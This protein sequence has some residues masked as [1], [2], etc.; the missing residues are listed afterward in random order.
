MDKKE[1]I[2]FEMTED[3]EHLPNSKAL[4]TYLRC[5]GEMTEGVDTKSNKVLLGKFSEIVPDLTK[6]ELEIYIS[7]TK[8]CVKRARPIKDFL[9]FTYEIS[10]C[11]KQNDNQVN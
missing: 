10:V 8:G 4:K 9:D 1:L 5:F 7:M 2:K 6:E 11:F 3:L